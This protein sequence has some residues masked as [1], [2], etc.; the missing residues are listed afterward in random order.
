MRTLALR[1]VFFI[2]CT[3]LFAC[4]EPDKTE[5]SIG[6]NA[7][8]VTLDPRYATD[9]VSYRIT[10]LLYQSLINFDDQ[11]RVIPD[12]TNWQQISLKHY[13]FT[14][15]DNSQPF[16]HGKPIT[17]QDI[18]AT[19]DSVLDEKTISPHR[20]SITM[21]KS[22]EIVDERT[23]DF[24]L[25]IDDPLFPGRLVISVM[26]ADLIK[27]KHNFQKYPIGSGSFS[28]FG[29]DD[30]SR[31][32]L[33]RNRD[34][35]RFNFLT[36][37]DPTVRILKLLRGELDL[38]Q[39]DL[40]PEVVDWLADN[41]SVA[42]EKHEGDT[43]TYIGFNLQDELTGQEKIRR[44]IAY[45]IDREAIIKYVMK[46]NARLAGAIFSAA[47]WAGHM[48]MHGVD[49]RPDKAREI[50][51]ELGF[52]ESKP[53]RLSYKISNNPFRL[54]LATIIQNQLKQVGIEIKI[55]SYDWGT[56][57]SDIKQ[58]RFQLYS[59]SWV[60]LKMPDIFRYV[61]HSESFPPTGAN[62]GRLQDDNVDNFIEAAESEND[63][64]SQAII[65]RKLQDYLLK[66]LPY[67]PLWYEDTILARRKDISG[68]TLATDGNFDAMK[69]IE[70]ID[71]NE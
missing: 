62:R 44:A 18:K 69:N 60:G 35:Q 55:Q 9:A 14:L 16:H 26:P 46:D 57:Y 51:K 63:L 53:L 34:K 33:N 47:H 1:L 27:A 48:D 24:H 8:P 45:A 30:E 66:V 56:F 71:I 5:I 23:V 29:W 6:L 36:V 17:A 4:S 59:L 54:R 70:R 38:V 32:V 7:S 39:G 42:I 50:L 22:I 49:F 41:E 13:R 20:G 12:I 28:F 40:S 21:I 2:G 37:K 19:Y 64:I 15:N 61:F 67:V 65:Y 3:F 31:L 43:F 68:Y 58:G 52:N 10:R 25:T 11:F